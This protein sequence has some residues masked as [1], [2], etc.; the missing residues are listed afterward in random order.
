MV[1]EM[2]LKLRLRIFDEIEIQ[3]PLIAK[4]PVSYMWNTVYL[5]IDGLVSRQNISISISASQNAPQMC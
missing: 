3:M 1:I 5:A 4:L 2:K